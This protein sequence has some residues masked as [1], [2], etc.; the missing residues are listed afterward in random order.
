MT[1]L[2]FPLSLRILYF[3]LFLLCSLLLTLHFVVSFLRVVVS[4]S[5]LTFFFFPGCFLDRK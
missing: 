3:V 1:L 5:F 4:L 2:R